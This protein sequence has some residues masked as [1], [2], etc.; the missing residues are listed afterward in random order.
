MID[1][2][3]QTMHEE[4][5]GKDRSRCASS[6]DKSDYIIF[7]QVERMIKPEPHC[8]DGNDCSRGKNTI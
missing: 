7:W 5:F 3:D 2:D 1:H 4:I 6:S 8:F